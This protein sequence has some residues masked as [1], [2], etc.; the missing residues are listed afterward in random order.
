MDAAEQAATAAANGIFDVS[1]L[2]S[3]HAEDTARKIQKFARTAKLEV[4]GQLPRDLL[5]APTSLA[6]S[7]TGFLVIAHVPLVKQGSLM[8]IFQHTP[9]PMPADGN[10]FVS[11]DTHHD[12]IAISPDL[13][14]FFL[15]NP[16]S[17]QLDCTK[18]RVLRLPKRQRSKEDCR[19]V[20]RRPSS[21]SPRPLH[22]KPHQGEHSLQEVLRH[23]SAHRLSSL[24]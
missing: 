14:N 22:R 17:L 11:I 13:K 10:L 7:R 5:H 18:T 1:T 20:H 8:G 12:T 21:L 2:Q 19:S 4:V 6:A 15:T 24:G 9:L 16:A 23:T 3:I